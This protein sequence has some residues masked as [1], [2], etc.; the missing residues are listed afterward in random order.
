MAPSSD[1]VP[2]P[3]A[4]A[5]PAATEVRMKSLREVDIGTSGLAEKPKFLR[6]KGAGAATLAHPGQI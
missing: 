2:A 1:G 5:P 4:M 3:R 6:D